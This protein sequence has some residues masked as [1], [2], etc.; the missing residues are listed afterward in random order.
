MGKKPLGMHPE[1]GRLGFEAGAMQ[2]RDMASPSTPTVGTP[3]W[4][5]I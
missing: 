3:F 5:Q 4:H 1:A 2:K